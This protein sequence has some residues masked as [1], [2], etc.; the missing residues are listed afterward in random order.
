V[1]LSKQKSFTDKSD[2]ESEPMTSTPSTLKGVVRGRVIELEREPGLP[3]GQEVRVTIESVLGPSL[4]SSPIFPSD[5]ARARWDEAWNDVKDLT[6][7]EGLRRAFG[8][9]AEDAEEVDKFLE[10]NRTQRKLERR[11]PEL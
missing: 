7:G 9:W 3:D 10:W 2:P 6:P 8:A 1:I 4:A 5:E 11:S